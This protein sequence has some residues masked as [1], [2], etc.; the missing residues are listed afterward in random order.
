MTPNAE[1]LSQAKKSLTGKWG[2]AI[3]TFVVYLILSVALQSIPTLGII[4][5]L[6]L[7]GPFALG[8]CIFSVNIARNREARLEQMFDGFKNWGTAI[9]AYLLTAVFV[10]LWLLLLIVPGIIAA[11]SYS[12][13]LYI[14]VDEPELGAYEAI[15]KSKMMMDGYKIKLLGLTFMFIGISLLCVLTLGIGFLWA[16]PWMQVTMA[17]FYDDVKRGAQNRNS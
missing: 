3:A 13:T 11:L 7:S 6:V 1:L 12:L 16:G 10:L 8:L 14:L 9:A 15:D 17:K 2:V 4:V 5:G